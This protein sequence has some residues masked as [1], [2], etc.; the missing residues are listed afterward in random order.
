MNNWKRLLTSYLI[1]SI[2]S[3]VTLDSWLISRKQS[4]I[5]HTEILR[6]KFDAENTEL[7]KKCMKI[8]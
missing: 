2:M 6:S 1:P 8:V 7:L 4:Y 5:D 3:A